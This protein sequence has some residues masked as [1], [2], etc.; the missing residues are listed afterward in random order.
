MSTRETVYVYSAERQIWR[1]KTHLGGGGANYLSCVFSL[2]N[3][4]AGWGVQMRKE[5]QRGEVISPPQPS[6]SDTTIHPMATL[7]KGWGV[8]LASVFS[9]TLHSQPTR[10]Q[11]LWGPPSRFFS[12]GISLSVHTAHPT[13]PSSAPPTYSSQSH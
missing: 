6:L 4:T 2:N 5:A 12:A 8:S 11:L 13:N 3:P 7:T 9:L 10:P 1:K